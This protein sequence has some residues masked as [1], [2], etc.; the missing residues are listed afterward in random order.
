MTIPSG[1]ESARPFLPT[2][3]F[4]TSRAFYEALGF[5]KLLNGDVA[6]FGIGATSFILNFMMQLMVDDLDGWWAHIQ[7]LDLPGRFGVPAPKPPEMQPW[8]LRVTYV[9]DP[10]GVLWH[11]A[12][13]QEL[14][15]YGVQLLFE[16]SLRSRKC[17]PI[18]SRSP[19]LDA[20]GTWMSTQKLLQQRSA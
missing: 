12:Q 2:E 17:V 1:T 19:R 20:R 7:G 10:A 4:E 11:V 6:I 9:V 8:G 13:R 18:R 14:F 15:R 3:D 5:T 16:I